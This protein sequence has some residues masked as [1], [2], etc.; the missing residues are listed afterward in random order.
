MGR[1]TKTVVIT[2]E[3]RDKGKTFLLTEMPAVR[4]ERW[5]SRVLALMVKSGATVTPEAADAG[6]QGLAATMPASGSAITASEASTMI[7]ALQDPSLEDWWTCVQYVHAPG[8]PPMAIDLGDACPIEEIATIT[9]LRMEVLGLHV[10]FFSN[11][12]PSTSASPSPGTIH[13]GSRPTRMSRPRLA[14]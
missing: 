5:A 8:Q 13:T 3:G 7:T 6:M 12:K 14:R 2:E 9:H 4:A 1:K 10:D 11:G